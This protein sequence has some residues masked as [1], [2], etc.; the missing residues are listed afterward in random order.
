MDTILESS[1]WVLQED[2]RMGA[3]VRSV[4]ASLFLLEGNTK[5]DRSLRPTKQLSKLGHDN[6]WC[7]S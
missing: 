5:L 4:P 7:T 6:E 1:K 3:Q 2:P